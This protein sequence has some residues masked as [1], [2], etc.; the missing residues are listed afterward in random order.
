MEPAPVLMLI[1][2][3][4]TGDCL[5]LVQKNLMAMSRDLQPVIL[6][7]S[8]SWSDEVRVVDTSGMYVNV[9]GVFRRR[10]LSVCTNCLL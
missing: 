3:M 4:S 5:A 8:A 6:R 9:G 7:S 10:S 2:M 1:E